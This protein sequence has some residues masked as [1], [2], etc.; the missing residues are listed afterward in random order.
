MILK[1]KSRNA[2]VLLQK[3]YFNKQMVKVSKSKV[4]FTLQFVV[5][6]FKWRLTIAFLLDMTASSKVANVS[7]DLYKFKLMKQMLF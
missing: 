2:Y 7:V 5:Q 4:T 6:N 3:Y 1:V